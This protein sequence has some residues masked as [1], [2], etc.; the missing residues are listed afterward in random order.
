M[1]AMHAIQENPDR[2]AQR[3]QEEEA[4]RGW[5]DAAEIRA[6]ANEILSLL[7]TV[8]EEEVDVQDR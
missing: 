5:N 6:M 1:I 3:W 8:P 2:F 7:G 4:A